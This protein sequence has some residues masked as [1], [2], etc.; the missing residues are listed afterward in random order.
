MKRLIMLMNVLFLTIMTA[1]HAAHSAQRSR[2]EVIAKNGMAATSHPLATHIAIDILQQGG[3]AV[4][5]AIAANAALGLMEPMSCGIGGDLFAIV[6][7][8]KSEKLYGLNAGGRSPQSLNIGYFIENGYE[9]IPIRGP[10]SLSVPGCVDGWFELHNKFGALPMHEILQ[11]VIEYANEGVPMPDIIAGY[12]QNGLEAFGDKP[13][14]VDTYSIKNGVPEKGRIFRNPYLAQTYAKIA[15]G[16]REIFYQGEIAETIDQFVKQQ[17]GFLSF[18]DLSLHT[19]EWIDPVSTNYRGYDVWQLPP[20]GQGI[21]VLQMLNILETFDLTSFDFGSVDFIHAFLEAKKLVFED[22]AKFYAD[23]DFYNVPVEKLVSKEYAQQRAR[24]ID[25]QHAGTDYQAG[26]ISEGETVYLCTADKQ[27][28][29]VSLI[30][31]IYYGFG[32]GLAPDGL[33]F[34]LQNRGALFTLEKDHAN[35]YE[36]N[37]RPFHTIIPGFVTKSGE[38]YMAFGVMGGDFQPQG[39]VQVLCNIIDFGMNLQEAGDAPRVAHTG[40]ST[41]RG[42]KMATDG[43]EVGLEDY[44]PPELAD[45]LRARGHNVQVGNDVMFYGGYQAIKYDKEH[46]VYVGATEVR[47]DGQV[48]GY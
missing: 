41:P 23:M 25:M 8:A 30:Q 17:G 10:L 45:G 11:P 39:Q 33:G 29:M 15:S 9:Q 46:G 42:D 31:S 18:N 37:K 27:G 26:Q 20:N 43:G 14:F 5:A 19:S 38:P 24:L 2:S 35:V 3:S 28:N 47:K 48:A 22:R 21:A 36:S 12:W 32:S 13:N 16:G 1:N 34:V 6:W 4:D 7:D 40:S 44:F